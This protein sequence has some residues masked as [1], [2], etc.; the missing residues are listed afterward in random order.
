M[1]LQPYFLR[2]G[3][4][5]L[6]LIGLGICFM[7]SLKS[8]FMSNPG[9]NAVILTLTLA[10][11][12]YAVYQL[13]RLK[14]DTEVLEDLKQGQWSF[15]SLQQAFFLEPILSFSSERKKDLDP[16]LSR[17][18]VNSLAD[19]L[20][21]ERVL[22]RYLIGL[23]VFLGLLGT[24]WGLS[25]TIVSITHLIQ[26]MPSEV[27]YSADFLTLLKKSLENPLTG[28]GTAF[29]SSLFGLGG[30]L[31]IGFIELQVG[32][33]YSRFLNE[34]DF[35]LTSRSYKNEKASTS[36]SAPLGFLQALLT[37]NVESI[38]QLAQLMEKTE[39]NE[40][41]KTVLLDKLINTVATTSEQNKTH[42]ALMVKLAEGQLQLQS[43]LSN[44]PQGFDDESQKCLQNIE[45]TLSLS[46]QSQREDREELLKKL[47]EEMRLIARAIASLNESDRLAS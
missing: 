33:A 16:Q 37:K 25:Q 13:L 40:R 41:Q 44:V 21:N 8:I 14:K 35:Y 23:L 3:L 5:L 38:D 22:P 24:F 18:L 47:K 29:S 6:T 27:S 36:S 45:R 31:V 7:K 10:G 11:I 30:S 17:G 19:R 39:K 20:E 42:H 1:K 43:L 26:K 2:I 4:T 9:L 46:L 34:V 12:G 15:S 32:H 28:M